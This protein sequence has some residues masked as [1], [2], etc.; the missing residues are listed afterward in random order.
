VV[1]VLLCIQF[2]GIGYGFWKNQY[3]N[4]Y[5]PAASYLKQHGTAGSLIMANGEFAFEFGFDGRLVDDVRLG[6]F[7]GKR[8]EFYVRDVWYSD[9][10]ERAETRDPAVYRHV[11]E[12]LMEHYHEV[13]RNPSYTIYQLR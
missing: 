3:R 10:L 11:S 1:A 4:E 2:L 8:P 5:L 9:W 12:A 6:Y 13:F 7:S